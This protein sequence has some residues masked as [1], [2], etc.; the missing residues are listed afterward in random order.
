MVLAA[1]WLVYRASKNND[2]PIARLFRMQSGCYVAAA[3]GVSLMAV[4]LGGLVS[5]YM[6]GLSICALVWAALV[7]ANWRRSALTFGP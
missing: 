1:F 7:P 5:P 3:F 2:L 4:E 6:H